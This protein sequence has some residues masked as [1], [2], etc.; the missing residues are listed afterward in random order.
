ME[1]EKQ[2]LADLVNSREVEVNDIVLGDVSS[3]DDIPI[4]ST[5][6][7]LTTTTKKKKKKKYF[8]H[9]K[10]LQRQQ[11]CH[12]SI[13]MRKHRASVPPKNKPRRS[14]AL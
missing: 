8:G 10:L 14:L 11:E 2:R 3:D 13:G 7:S 1:A 5:L 9:T 12:Q 4:V 6:P